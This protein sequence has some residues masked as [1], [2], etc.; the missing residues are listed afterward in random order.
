[1]YTVCVAGNCLVKFALITDSYLLDIGCQSWPPSENGGVKEK[2]IPKK[3]H[4]NIIFDCI[5]W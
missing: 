1:M 5:F 3:G 4:K 2:N